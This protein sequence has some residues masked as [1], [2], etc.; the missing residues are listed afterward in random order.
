MTVRPVA[1]ICMPA[2][3]RRVWNAWLDKAPPEKFIA[4]AISI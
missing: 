1:E 4:L 2:D 3:V